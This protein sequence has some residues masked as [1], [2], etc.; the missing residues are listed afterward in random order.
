MEFA[1][2]ALTMM[3]RKQRTLVL[4]DRRQPAD[5]VSKGQSESTDFFNRIGQ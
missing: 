3:D 1:H 2:H 4:R 5:S